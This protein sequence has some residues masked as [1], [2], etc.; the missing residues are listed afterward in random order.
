MRRRVSPKSCFT[1]L[2]RQ[3]VTLLS[4]YKSYRYRDGF[5]TLKLFRKQSQS[6]THS[7]NAGT[8]SRLSTY[9]CKLILF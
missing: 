3:I 5:L 7:V 9:H 6:T 1:Q 4:S 2:G 8:L